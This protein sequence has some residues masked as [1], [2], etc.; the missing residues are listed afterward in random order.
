VTIL[1]ERAGRLIA[2]AEAATAKQTKRVLHLARN[3]HR[4]WRV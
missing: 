1:A 4:G 2:E 3:M